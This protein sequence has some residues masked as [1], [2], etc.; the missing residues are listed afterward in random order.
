MAAAVLVSAEQ[1]QLKP[2]DVLSG[3]SKQA[4]ALLAAGKDIE[5][6]DEDEFLRRLGP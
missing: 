6:M 4:Q 3:K 5:I 1:T 2:G